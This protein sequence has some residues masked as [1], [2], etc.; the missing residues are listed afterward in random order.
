M[1]ITVVIDDVRKSWMACRSHV[2]T[3]LNDTNKAN[4]F[5]GKQIDKVGSEIKSLDNEN[6]VQD[7]I[8]DELYDH[9]PKVEHDFKKLEELHNCLVECVKD[10]TDTHD[11]N[12][13][14]DFLKSNDNVQGLC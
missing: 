5:K 12:M 3:E 9:I 6:E 10:L 2:A 8:N 11:R 13:E 14:E 7:T 4:A 1:S